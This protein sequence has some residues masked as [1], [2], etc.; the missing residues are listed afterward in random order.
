MADVGVASGPDQPKRV[1]E[2]SPEKINSME[3]GRREI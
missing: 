1:E 3:S 2:G